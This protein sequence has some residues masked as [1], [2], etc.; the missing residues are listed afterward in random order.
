MMSRHDVKM[1]IFNDLVVAFIEWAKTESCT[2]A[3]TGGKAS[4]YER[5][6]SCSTCM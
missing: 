6:L 4:R 2:C 3:Q 1:T 5:V